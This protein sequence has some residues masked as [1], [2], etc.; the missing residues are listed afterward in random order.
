MLQSWRKEF[1]AYIPDTMSM[2]DDEFHF[3][4]FPGLILLSHR[5][6][7]TENSNFGAMIINFQKVAWCL[8][9]MRITKLLG[10]DS[11]DSCMENIGNMLKSFKTMKSD[12]CLK[13]HFLHLLLN[14]FSWNCVVVHDKASLGK[15]SSMYICY[16]RAL[17]LKN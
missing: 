8:F 9:Q 1:V 7:I 17:R 12:L 13:M 14:F 4:R 3:S 16:G 6:E 15:C 2:N 11:G 10:S 5:K